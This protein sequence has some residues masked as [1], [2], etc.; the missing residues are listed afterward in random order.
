MLDDALWAA[1]T[2]KYQRL[3]SLVPSADALVVTI[4][5]TRFDVCDDS[6]VVSALPPAKRVER[7]LRVL[8]AACPPGKKIIARSFV[9]THT[10]LVCM[11]VQLRIQALAHL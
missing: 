4:A 9:H 7:L 2:A 11:R 8:A 10:Y 3:W 6:T 1:L 5:E